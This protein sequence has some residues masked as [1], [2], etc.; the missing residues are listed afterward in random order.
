MNKNSEV[1]KIDKLFSLAVKKLVSKDFSNVK[2]KEFL[3]KKGATSDEADDVIQKLEQYS[4]INEE[5]LVD[6][7]LSFCNQKHYGFNRII[8]MVKNRKVSLEKIEKIKKDEARELAQAR[9]MS[10]SLVKRHRK[11]SENK[12]KQKVYYTLIRYGFDEN[13]ATICVNEIHISAI[14]ELNM[15]ILEYKKL[16]S[17][18]SR[19]AKGKDL[20]NKIIKSLLV[21]GFKRED[22]DKVLKE[23]KYETN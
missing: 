15:L 10:K 14:D 9:L 12:L 1:N 5:E 23:K 18:Y 8:F 22:V 3:I 21:K 19:K 4:L 20:V 7:I 17:R 6:N 2:M 16:F 11:N 13:V